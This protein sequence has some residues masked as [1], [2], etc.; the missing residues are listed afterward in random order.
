[1]P[2]CI[3][4]GAVES[5][6]RCKMWM[7][8]RVWGSQTLGRLEVNCV[9]Q[10]SGQFLRRHDGCLILEDVRFA[11]K[12]RPFYFESNWSSDRG[13]LQNVK[14]PVCHVWDLH[15]ALEQRAL[16]KEFVQWSDKSSP[17]GLWGMAW[18]GICSS[19]EQMTKIWGHKGARHSS[20]HFI[21]SSSFQVQGMRLRHRVNT[22]MNAHRYV[23]SM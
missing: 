22:H 14:D 8:H 23:L 5:Q 19:W 2:T 11:R 4:V 9:G 17:A 15:L 16:R 3:S 20:E 10:R 21:F 1:M 12:G 13:R 6:I 18:G 7:D